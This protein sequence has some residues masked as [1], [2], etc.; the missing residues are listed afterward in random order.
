MPPW[1]CFAARRTQL[2]LAG[3]VK[4]QQRREAEDRGL[5]LE[6]YFLREELTVPN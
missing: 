6:D 1:T 3:Q 5:R 2:L 4:P